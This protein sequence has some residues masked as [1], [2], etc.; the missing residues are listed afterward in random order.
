MSGVSCFSGCKSRSAGCQLVS[1]SFLPPQ[2]SSRIKGI[3][4]DIGD[5]I[6]ASRTLSRA[7][8]VLAASLH[9]FQFDILGTSLTDDEV[10]IS[11][12]LRE[13][14]RFLTQVRQ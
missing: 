9:Q 8:R 10:I 7:K 14:A 11:N 1:P 6:E 12:S 13:F 5:V 2:T 4:R 3:S